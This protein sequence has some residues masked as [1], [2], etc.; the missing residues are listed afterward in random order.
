[1]LNDVRDRSG[2]SPGL[3]KLEGPVQATQVNPPDEVTE[4]MVGLPEVCPN[5]GGSDRQEEP[6]IDENGT[7]T[8]LLTVLCTSCG[9]RFPDIPSLP[10]SA[11][12]DDAEKSLAILPQKD[13]R[14]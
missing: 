13:L 4:T 2:I 9:Y 8:N 10:L 1:M 14:E 5:C 11:E 3:E 7:L 12:A 6:F